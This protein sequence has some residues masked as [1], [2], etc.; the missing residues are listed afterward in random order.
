MNDR[1]KLRLYRSITWVLLGIAALVLLYTLFVGALPFQVGYLV[2]L[3]VG[4]AL[5]VFA[6]EVAVRRGTSRDS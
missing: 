2:A 6:L 4:V 1:R 3:F 5:L